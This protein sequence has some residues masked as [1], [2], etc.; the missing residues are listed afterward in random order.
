MEPDGEAL[1]APVIGALSIVARQERLPLPS[2]EVEGRTLGSAA[3]AAPGPAQPPA[4]APAPE[5][6][7]QP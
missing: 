6:L 7:R 5:S 4:A 2:A 3:L 1:D